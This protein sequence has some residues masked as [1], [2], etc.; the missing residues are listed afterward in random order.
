MTWALEFHERVLKQFKRLSKDDAARIEEFLEHRL[1]A[2][3]NPRSLG[4]ALKG[5]RFEHLWRYR[6]GDY[7]IVCDIQDQRVVVLVLNI[8]HRSDVYR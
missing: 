8:G 4:T 3:G 1:L 2:A 7:R 5:S 6:V